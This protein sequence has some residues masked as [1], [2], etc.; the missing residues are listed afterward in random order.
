MTADRNDALI[1]PI[2]AVRMGGQGPRVRVRS[3]GTGELSTVP[4]EI[5]RTTPDGVEIVA[6]IEPGDEL[7]LGAQPGY[8]DD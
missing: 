6:G 2:G 1:V 5:G 4:V 8:A 3:P 7:L